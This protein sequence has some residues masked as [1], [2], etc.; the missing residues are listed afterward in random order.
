MKMSG[1]PDL[2]SREVHLIRNEPILDCLVKIHAR[3]APWISLALGVLASSLSKKGVDFAP[4]AVALVA[5]AW[6][7]P[8]AVSRWLHPPASG[9][10]ERRIHHFLRTASPTVTVLLYTNVLFFV[11]PI[12]FGSANLRSIN[13]VVPLCFAAMA[14]FTALPGT[15]APWFSNSRACASCG[16]RWCSSRRSCRQ[17]P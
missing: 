1:L 14:F 17:P 8:L 3:Y 13:I 6:L 9:V 16:R 5:L 15:T 12:W 7:L 11:V 10:A 2:P 4:K